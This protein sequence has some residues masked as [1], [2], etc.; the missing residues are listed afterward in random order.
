MPT[1]DLTNVRVINGSRLRNFVS[2]FSRSSDTRLFT[3]AGLVTLS[4]TAEKLKI[5]TT[6]ANPGQL[7]AALLLK[8][9]DIRTSGAIVLRARVKGTIVVEETGTATSGGATTLTDTGKAW[10]VNEWTGFFVCI[11]AGTGIGQCRSVVSNTAT[12]LTVAAW[13]IQP[14][15]TSVYEIKASLGM[16]LG[17]YDGPGN[18]MALGYAQSIDVL[19]N[20]LVA[21]MS[22]SQ[23]AS[24]KINHHAGHAYDPEDFEM[25]THFVYDPVGD[26]LLLRIYIDGL[27]VSVGSIGVAA[28]A[29]NGLGGTYV[30][31]P[32]MF[33]QC[34]GTYVADSVYAEVSK[35]VVET[36]AGTED[37]VGGAKV[38]TLEGVLTG[39]GEIG[40][41]VLGDGVEGEIV[42][43]RDTN[44]T[45]RFN[46]TVWKAI[47]DC[48]GA[49]VV[50][51]NNQTLGHD[52]N[53][54]VVTGNTQIN[55]I[56]T[57]HWE[58]GVTVK[59]LFSGT[60][61]VKHNTAGGGGT[62]VMKLATSAD[63]NAA[64]DSLLF[65]TY[66]GTV[67]HEITRKVA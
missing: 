37:I 62:A 60:P 36:G 25:S 15:A 58:A 16:F 17:L 1:R 63:F 35:F 41:N 13:T 8:S 20:E 66:D 34:I 56:T 19:A 45:Y 57:Q 44:K 14:N 55:A 31:Y 38:T 5:P 27:L 43:A 11:T 28:A 42:H 50:A 53:F 54:F 9:L 6:D 61:V 46:G 4:I 49:D 7:G 26:A 67:W 10:V 18:Y 52:G 3:S 65:L 51:A 2:D 21:G 47:G 39:A 48:K 24:G 12:A 33:T 64:A 29:P 59:L 40:D 30:F 23:F 22:Y 32:A